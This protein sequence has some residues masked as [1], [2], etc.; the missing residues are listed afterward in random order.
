M[1]L[2]RRQRLA[3][4]LIFPLAAGFALDRT[5]PL[6]GAVARLRDEGP[7]GVVSASAAQQVASVDALGRLVARASGRP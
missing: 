7:A 2:E 3:K 6:E 4:V 1:E 5:A